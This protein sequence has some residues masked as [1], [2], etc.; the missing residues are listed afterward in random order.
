[1]QTDPLIF[2]SEKSAKEKKIQ[3][4]LRKRRI[5]AFG[6]SCRMQILKLR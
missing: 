5:F 1:M 6:V 4:N 3:S 2:H